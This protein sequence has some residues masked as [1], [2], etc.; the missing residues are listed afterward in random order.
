MSYIFRN[1]FVAVALFGLTLV[2]LTVVA[3]PANK[4]VAL[5][6]ELQGVWTIVSGEEDGKPMR[7]ARGDKIEVGESVYN[8]V[9]IQRDR[10]IWVDH[11]GGALVFRAKLVAT[12][13]QRH[14]RIWG[15]RGQTE[16]E[17]PCDLI[18]RLKADELT[19]CCG[20]DG[21]APAE[22]TAKKGSAQAVF[23]LKREQ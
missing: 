5:P 21:K 3:Q 23:V 14:I 1:T 16:R 15:D 11:S 19:L 8:E 4:T 13:P 2:G 18:Y 17:G 12:Q 20:K 7:I 10:W 9:I 6:A 22:F